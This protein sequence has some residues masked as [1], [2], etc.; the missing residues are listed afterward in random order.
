MLSK[1][2]N[3]GMYDLIDP[4]K[5]SQFKLATLYGIY[6]QCPSEWVLG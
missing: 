6:N 5:M 4:P 3:H 1:I 2:M